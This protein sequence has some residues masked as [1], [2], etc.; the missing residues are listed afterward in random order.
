MIVYG[1]ESM[2]IFLI[3][4]V[5]NPILKG[6]DIR[7]KGSRKIESIQNSEKYKKKNERKIIPKKRNQKYIRKDH[8]K[9]RSYDKSTCECWNCGDKGHFEA[10]CPKQKRGGRIY[11]QKIEIPK[12][13][14]PI[15][16]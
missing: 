14:H 9:V 1:V 10:E 6:R 13:L 11:I 7:N 16:E 8:K 4:D 3:Q 15:E 12:K 2:M 5:E